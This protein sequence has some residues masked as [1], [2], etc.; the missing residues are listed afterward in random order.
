MNH[1][2]PIHTLLSQCYIYCMSLYITIID[3]AYQKNLIY[4]SIGR[5]QYYKYIINIKNMWKKIDISFF[6][7]EFEKQQVMCWRWNVPRFNENIASQSFWYAVIPLGG[8][9]SHVALSACLATDIFP[10]RRLFRTRTLSLSSRNVSP[11]SP[12]NSAGLWKLVDARD[13]DGSHP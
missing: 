4:W 5:K 3:I 13:I 10:R 6:L 7:N 12:R 8:N 1:L 2:I 9:K 11:K